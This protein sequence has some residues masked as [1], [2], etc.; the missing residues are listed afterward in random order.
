MFLL[1]DVNSPFYFGG[2]SFHQR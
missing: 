1:Y 2:C